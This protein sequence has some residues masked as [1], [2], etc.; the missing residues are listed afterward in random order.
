MVGRRS[1][2]IPNT[3][4]AEI[5]WSI[6]FVHCAAADDCDGAAAESR[7]NHLAEGVLGRKEGNGQVCLRAE[8]FERGRGES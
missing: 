1:L 2:I 4:A 8:R 5:E 3:V 7:T 6:L